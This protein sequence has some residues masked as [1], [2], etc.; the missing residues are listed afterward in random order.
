MSER[1]HYRAYV[2]DKSSSINAHLRYGKV[3]YKRVTYNGL[4]LWMY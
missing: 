1:G 2:Y 4:F 3:M